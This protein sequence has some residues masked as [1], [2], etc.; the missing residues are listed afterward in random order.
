[1]EWFNRNIIEYYI[2]SKLFI[3]FF[4]VYLLTDKFNELNNLTIYSIN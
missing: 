3:D 2:T 1:M 4:G